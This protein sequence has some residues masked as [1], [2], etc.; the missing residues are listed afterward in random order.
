MQLPTARAV[1]RHSLC[2]VFHAALSV[3]LPL[4]RH[5]LPYRLHSSRRWWSRSLPLSTLFHITT[6]TDWERARALGTYRAPSLDSEGF[7]HLSTSA[8]WRKT[9]GR[10]FKGQS[11]LV[12]L[13]LDP[14]G[15]DV[16]FEPADGDHFPHLYGALPVSAVL[17]TTPF[18]VSASGDVAS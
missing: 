4:E 5:Q 2:L 10:F 16:R 8:Q 3:R 17:R 15:L 13:E 11:H 14:S 18:D 1:Q 12:L 7:I 6:A 9:A